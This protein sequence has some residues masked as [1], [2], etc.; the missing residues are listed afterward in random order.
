L[1]TS[2][3]YT[4]SVTTAIPNPNVSNRNDVKRWLYSWLFFLLR[5]TS[6]LQLLITMM[7]CLLPA[8]L[9]SQKKRYTNKRQHNSNWDCRA[10][11]DFIRS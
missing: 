9:P 7:H 5:I 3:N 6:S 10:V 4:Y 8:L 2:D 11:M 1:N